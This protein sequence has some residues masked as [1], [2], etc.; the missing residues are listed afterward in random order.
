MAEDKNKVI[1]YAD[2]IEKF[3][4]LEDDEAGRLIKHFFRYINDLN[5]KPPDR[6][7]ELSFIDIQHTLKRDLKKWEK[8]AENSRENGKNG[9]R[10]P[11][12]QKP[13]E[14][15]QVISEPTKPV[16]DIVIGSVI[17]NKIKHSTKG[18]A[19]KAPQ[20]EF[21][22]CKNFWLDEFKQ[23]WTFSGAKGKALKSIIDKIKTVVKSAGNE[24][25]D[26][27]VI[28]T[29]KTICLRLPEY[30]KNKDLEV[31]DQKFNEIINEIKSNNGTG[32]TKDSSGKPISKYAPQNFT[33]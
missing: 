12:P 33:D 18:G 23:G 1:V 21:V 28:D 16:I 26:K 13:T 24:I 30:Y 8:R 14:T 9:G 25:G 15:H 7:T 22:D 32:T 10:P 20:P 5:P 6:I 2:W 27:T 19:K 3:E 4:A 29:F 11:N 17:D 31:L